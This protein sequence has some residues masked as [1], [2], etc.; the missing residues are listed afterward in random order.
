M[1]HWSNT[2]IHSKSLFIIDF[3]SKSRLFET[4]SDW[5]S[6]SLI[7]TA[8]SRKSGNC[9]IN[10]NTCSKIVVPPTQAAYVFVLH[11]LRTRYLERKR[12]L[13]LLDTK[14]RLSC[15]PGS[16]G[17]PTITAFRVNRVLWIG[18]CP[19]LIYTTI[20]MIFFVTYKELRHDQMNIKMALSFQLL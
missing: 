3:E 18:F 6:D 11:Y 8:D 4:N 1:I 20:W 13:F 9:E 5:T 16:P 14:P 19:W 2:I 7:C 15:S 12:K 10:G 17:S